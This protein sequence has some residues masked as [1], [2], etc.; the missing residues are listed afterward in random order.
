VNAPNL[1]TRVSPRRLVPL[2]LEGLVR[3]WDPDRRLLLTRV[4]AD[5]EVRT[6]DHLAARYCVMTSLGL[7]RARRAGHDVPLEPEVIL[8]RGLEAGG[9]DTLDAL[10]MGLW[11]DAELGTDHAS[12]LL[13]ALIERVR[14]PEARLATIGR[15]LAWALEALSRHHERTHDAGARAA[16]ESLCRF[17][18][19]RCHH[20]E[21]GLFTHAVEPRG[22]LGPL[23]WLPPQALF[24]T[25]IY[26]VHALA[27]YGRVFE[28]APALA[29][30]AQVMRRLIALRDDHFG[31]VWRY[32]AAS[33]TVPEPFPIYSV[34]QHG[35]APMALHL[36]A[37]LGALEALPTLRESLRWLGENQLGLEM[38]DSERA[39]IYRSIRRAYPMNRL[40]YPAGRLP[41]LQPL[42]RRPAFLRLNASCRA[43]ELGWL[44]YAWAGRESLLD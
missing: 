14:A 32:H 11:A 34:H 15:P 37:E 44:L 42:T 39:M 8:A 3:M 5:G 10:A 2:A 9:V 6:N 18:L 29:V 19:E 35:M 26:W 21:T 4:V 12:R 23:P 1:Y 41:F 31:W 22:P 33:G 7:H 13:P 24:S 16:A 17:A 28:H 20:P 30:A 27:T 36:L 40:T 25:Q 43:Y 38:I